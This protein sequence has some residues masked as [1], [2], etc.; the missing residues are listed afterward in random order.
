MPIHDD[1]FVFCLQ[2]RGSLHTG[3]FLR[4]MTPVSSVSSGQSLLSSLQWTAAESPSSAHA[5]DQRRNYSC[6][7]IVCCRFPY[8][9]HS[10][11]ETNAFFLS[12]LYTKGLCKYRC[13]WRHQDDSCPHTSFCVFPNSSCSW[14]E[15]NA[16]FLV[17]QRVMQI[18]RATGGAKTAL[19]F[20][21]AWLVLGPRVSAT[22]VGYPA[23]LYYLTIASSF[24]P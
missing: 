14:G 11:G 19:A 18:T 15:T 4:R 1:T 16:F 21:G 7:H 23:L 20:H 17:H 3:P 24:D 9:S 2:W 10:L 6:S 5:D 12:S 13:H 8:R 22:C